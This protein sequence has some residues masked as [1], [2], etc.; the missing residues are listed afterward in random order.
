MG[1]KIAL[2]GFF[3]FLAACSSKIER[4]YVKG[5]SMG[6]VPEDLCSCAFEKLEEKF[7]AETLENM[8]KTGVIPD[9]FMEENVNAAQMCASEN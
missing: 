2:L 7:S 1:A 6:G 5:C 4:D 9:G 8:E 3:V